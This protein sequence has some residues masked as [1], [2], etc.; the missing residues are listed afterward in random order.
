M[1]FRCPGA[2]KVEVILAANLSGVSC[3]ATVSEDFSSSKLRG[4][5]PKAVKANDRKQG[6]PKL[7][8]MLELEVKM[9]KQ[10]V[11]QE[12]ARGI[13]D[14]ERKTNC[15]EN[16]PGDRVTTLELDKQHNVKQKSPS[17]SDSTQTYQDSPSKTAGNSTGIPKPMAAVKGTSKVSNSVDSSPLRSKSPSVHRSPCE[18]DRQKRDEPNVAL[19]SPMRTSSCDEVTKAKENARHTISDVDKRL[20]DVEEEELMS[21]KPMSPLM[22]GYRLPSNASS[23]LTHLTHPGCAQKNVVCGH[24]NVNPDLVNL[25]SIDLAMGECLDCARMSWKTRILMTHY[26]TVAGYLSD[27]EVLRNMNTANLMQDANGGYSSDSVYSR[28]RD[29]R[30]VFLIV[31]SLLRINSHQARR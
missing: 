4:L 31:S 10:V 12:T 1:V 7:K 16:N 2:D 19:V 27:G 8:R 5:K 11:R 28:R 24:V 21:V 17:R 23:H 26:S 13:A 18:V 20:K 6:S 15:L 29:Q 30:F 25:E 22:S 9:T 14:G 3:Q